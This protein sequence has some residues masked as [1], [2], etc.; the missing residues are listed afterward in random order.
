MGGTNVPD[1]MFI[2]S[3]Y[4]RITIVYTLGAPVHIRDT[5]VFLNFEMNS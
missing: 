4:D 5:I 1:G 3:N 2:R